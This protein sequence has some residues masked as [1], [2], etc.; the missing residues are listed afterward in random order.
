MLQYLTNSK[1][2]NKMP[3]ALTPEE[4]MERIIAKKTEQNTGIEAAKPASGL[5]I[6]KAADRPRRDIRRVFN[7]TK[8]KLTLPPD[9]VQA[10][11]EAGWHL[12]GFNDV[13]GRIEEALE[14]GY[15]FITQSELGGRLNSA[16]SEV[17]DI[18]D[19]VSFMAGKKENG[20][21]MRVYI[22]KIPEVDFRSNDKKLQERNDEI[23]RAIK[24][25]KNIKQGTSSDGFYDAGIS[26]KNI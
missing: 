9:I 4:K 24:Q 21:S 16:L 13:D 25:G 1:R 5:Q 7:G 2:E 14:A 20:D 26:V 15:E 11:K 3:R 8:L 17:T 22:M 19:K 10:Y 6:R 23:D 18:G 12:Y